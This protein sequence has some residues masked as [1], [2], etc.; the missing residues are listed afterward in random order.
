MNQ[1]KQNSLRAW[2]LAARPKTLSAALVP[3][4]AANALAFADGRLLPA[5]PFRWTPF[6]L[7]LLFA[8]T[9]QIAANFINDYVDFRRGT[10]EADRVGPQRA[11]ANGWITPSALKRG[12]VA[13]IGVAAA[14]GLGLFAWYLVR[15]S[16]AP[17]PWWMIGVGAACI[18]F[19]F[20][21]STYCSYHALGDLLVLIFFGFVPVVC[22]Y[23]L[24]MRTAPLA[25]WV[26]GAGCGM[27][28]NTLLAINNY[29]DR[30]DDRQKGKRT[31]HVLVGEY[32]CGGIYLTYGTLAAV[33]A[34]LVLLRVSLWPQV[35]V[36]IY[37]LFHLYLSFAA[38]IIHH[39]PALNG[40]LARTSIALLFYGL[41]ISAALV[42]WG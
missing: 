25:A 27:A 1:I 37:F 31:L 26:L 14:C 13:T 19:A 39:G 22:T 42:V 34:S 36:G 15:W 4:V 9:M 41:S 6:V 16:A 32:L 5:S 17:F 21:Y 29:R 24:Q 3:V 33:C 40:I 28:M 23:Y 8:L 11:M 18:L 10:D 30:A 7:T 12:I 35:F 2:F 38:A 20:L